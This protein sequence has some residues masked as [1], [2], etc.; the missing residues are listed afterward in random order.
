MMSNSPL[1]AMI[2]PAKPT[3]LENFFGQLLP[4]DGNWWMLML[5]RGDRTLH[6]SFDNIEAMTERVDALEAEGIEVFHAVA[7]FIHRYDEKKEGSKDYWGRKAE[8]IA[9]VSA[10]FLDIDVTEDKPGKAYATIEQAEEGLAR[11][12]EAFGMPYNYLVRS[13]GGLHVYWFLDV[14][15]PRDEWRRIALKLKDASKVAGLLA[16]PARTADP[17]SVLRPVGTTNRKGKYGPTGRQVEGKWCRFGKTN[18]EEFEAACDRLLSNQ[19]AAGRMPIPNTSNS[20]KTG[21]APTRP[22]RWFDDLTDDVKTRVLRSMLA[23]L[24]ACSVLDYSDWLSVGA[25]LAGVEGVPRDA[26]FDLWADWSQS[27]DEGAASWCEDSPDEQRRR[28]DGLTRSGVGALIVRAKAAGWLPDALC[29]S[30]DGQSAHDAVVAAQEAAC[31]RWTLAE[32]EAYM[33]EHVVYVKADNTYFLDGLSLPK[34]ALDTSLARRM[35]VSERQVTAS[36]LLKKGSGLIVDHLGYKP[37]AAR[38]YKDRNGRTFANRW[39]KHSIQPTRPN[40]EE[41]H[42]FVDLVKHFANGD[43]ETE[44]GIKRILTKYAYLYKHPSARIRHATLLIGKTEGCGKTTLTHDIP[45]A[46]FG[47]DNVRNVETRELSSDFNGYADSARILVLPELWIGNRK[48]A[49]V[50]ANNLKPLITDDHVP[51]V[52]KGKDGR[53]I[54]NVT[55]IFA[56]S[57]HADAAIFGELDRRYDVISTSA[58]AMPDELTAR[59]HSLIRE[60]PGALLWLILAAYGKSADSFNPNAPPPQTAAKVN[61]MESGRAVWA[62]QIRDAIGAYEWPFKGD[63]VAVSDVKQLLRR[64]FDPLPSDNAIRTELLN[65]VDGAYSILA[66]RRKVHGSEQKRVIVMRNINTWKDAGPS[67][68]YDHY[69]ETVMKKRPGLV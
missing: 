26:L 36:G 66:Q 56:S 57:N 9:F 10:F 41:A 37:G 54:E 62:Q 15:V 6:E 59:V 4:A 16:D 68:I 49:L 43:E 23:K 39:R 47:S 21:V 63:I 24:N 31:E 22:P 60:R 42:T 67:T 61:M 58:P 7:S 65:M 34:E 33:Q 8:N 44:A 51:L 28:F 30:S 55:T 14:D 12:V 46:L 25:A 19:L 27:T 3:N 32:A 18:L 38:T 17:A 20:A 40:N 48:D 45:S 53:T 2:P 11:F 52:K 1:M 64:E 29:D 5:K 69:E 35:P 50:Q 13:G